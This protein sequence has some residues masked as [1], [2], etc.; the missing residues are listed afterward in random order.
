MN[1]ENREIWEKQEKG[2]EQETGKVTGGG[3]FKGNYNREKKSCCEIL[4]F[5]TEK[6]ILINWNRRKREW[7]EGGRKG[8]QGRGVTTA[9]DWGTPFI[10]IFNSKSTFS[11]WKI[12][13]ASWFWNHIFSHWNMQK[14]IMRL[15]Q[16][17]WVVKKFNGLFKS[18]HYC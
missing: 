7:Y 2:A 16:T 15:C 1:K 6:W 18:V 12:K 4:E 5:P 3:G 10:I 13:Y 14:K 8:S 9:K 11:Y 17:C